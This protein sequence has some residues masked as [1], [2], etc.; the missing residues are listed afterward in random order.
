MRIT[1]S[2]GYFTCCYCVIYN[3]HSYS[4]WINHLQLLKSVWTTIQNSTLRFNVYTFVGKNIVYLGLI[5][6]LYQSV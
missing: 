4:R 3:S 1:I 6:T 2:Q 5:Y